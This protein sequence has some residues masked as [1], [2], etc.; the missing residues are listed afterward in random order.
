MKSIYP[1]LLLV[2][3]IFLSCNQ[4]NKFSATIDSSEDSLSSYLSLANDFNL[5]PEKRKQFNQKAFSII[6]DQPSDSL[7][8]V[9]LFKVANRY[10]NMDRLRDFKATVDII[11]EKT[12]SNQDTISRIKAYTYLG[13]FYLE[14]SVSDSAFMYYSKAEKMYL[15]RNNML[16]LAK[17][18]LN[19][20][21]LQFN[22]GDFLGSEITVFNALR[23]VKDEKNSV[24]T[25]DSYNLLGLIHNELGNYER[26]IE[27]NLKALNAIDDTTPSIFQS[28]AT[29]LNNIGY[30]YQH[31]NK[32]RKAIGFF[33]EGLEQKNLK[34][35]KA[36]LYA[37]LID[38]LAYSKFKTGDFT[39][40][41]EEFYQSLQLRDSL[42]LTSGILVSKMRL[43]EYFAFKNDSIKALKYAEESLIL[44]KEVKNYKSVLLALKR[45]STLQPKKAAFYAKQYIRINDS[46][47]SSERKIGEK[48]TR[49]EYETDQIKS[50]NSDLMIR[51]RN[52]VY[53]FSAFAV[54]GIL[55]L[56]IK[57]Q[58]TKNRELLFKQEQ[59]KANAEIYNLMLSQQSTIEENRIKEKNRVARELHDGVLGR[60]FG[61]R[62][63]LDSLNGFQ[64]QIAIKQ[65]TAYLSELK[66][67]EQDIR[68]ISHDLSKEKSEL[69]NNFV[70]ILDRLFE[71]QRK[72]YKSKFISVID[73]TIR[74]ESIDN[75]VKISL[76]RIIQESLQ[77]SNKYADSNTIKVSF[78]QAENN[79]K[80][81][82]SDDG[83]GFN[84]KTAK[85]GIG[86]QN[87]LFRV[88]ECNGQVEIKSNKGQGTTIIITIPIE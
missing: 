65:R 79:L 38:N 53:F 4:K 34:T 25:Y 19:K 9:N 22:V 67:I 60:M 10:Y 15:H 29:S 76:Y 48:F 83:I 27:Y 46:L 71:E 40:L 74:W 54:L 51:N 85:K 1:L 12:I 20:A 86:I 45:L 5:P 88:Q 24:I 49:I 68:E 3:F 72:T 73:A 16:D 39:G 82:I 42:K 69:I 43:S 21:L 30:I 6:I 77:N 81:E 33:I 63:N 37:M 26:A 70:V 52:M 64:D 8:T 7:N 47:Q 58:K 28:K 31:T 35:D 80:L 59:Q 11:L 44:A 75:A 62:M 66:N 14:K 84:L 55:I 32:H 56:I 78:S 17:T 36:S 41:P 57:T 61:V 87:I 18:R 23:A 2:L 13:D 50:E